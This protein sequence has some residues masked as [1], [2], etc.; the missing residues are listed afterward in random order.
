M[1]FSIIIVNFN[2]KNLLNNCIDSILNNC[3][4]SNYE[5]IVIDNGSKDGSVEMIKKQYSDNLK[6]IINQENKGFG[7]ANNKGAKIAMGEYLFFLNSDTVIKDDIFLELEQSFKKNKNTGIIAPKLLLDD[8]SEQPF[9]FGNFPKIINVIIKKFAPSQKY[10]E[11]SFKTDWVSGAALVIKKDIFEKIGG[12][13]EKIFMYF[14]DIDLCKRVNE[15][16]YDVV[17]NPLVKITHYC[18]KS[19]VQFKNR[20]EYYYRSQDYFYKKHYGPFKANLARM[21]R[22][23]KYLLIVK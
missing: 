9:A 21:L 10:K 7:S 18:A 5:I 15:L 8:G 20:K 6:V 22:R 12:F 11:S 23:I 1:I 17:V 14:E 19:P 3:D 4:R 16:G 13:D 2:T